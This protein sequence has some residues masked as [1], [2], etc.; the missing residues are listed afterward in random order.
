MYSRRFVEGIHTYAI[1]A[2]IGVDLLDGACEEARHDQ[3][4]KVSSRKTLFSDSF[5]DQKESRSPKLSETRGSSRG[6]AQRQMMRRRGLL[7][8]AW[9]PRALKTSNSSGPQFLELEPKW[10]RSF[11]IHPF[12]D[13]YPT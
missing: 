1:V 10:L 7:D 9:V 13:P 4:L 3:S 5:Y 11:N 8:L 6:G 12:L 2:T